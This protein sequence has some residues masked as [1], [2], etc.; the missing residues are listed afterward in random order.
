MAT[1]S[2]NIGDYFNGELYILEIQ[3]GKLQKIIVDKLLE[4]T[5]AFLLKATKSVI[6]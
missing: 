5:F 4:G 1:P 6:S 2:P 3:A